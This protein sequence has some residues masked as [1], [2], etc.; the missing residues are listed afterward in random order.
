MRWTDFVRSVFPRPNGRDSMTRARW[1]DVTRPLSAD[2]P[3]Y[4]G[5][6]KVALETVRDPSGIAV[7]RIALHTHAGT[8]MDLPPHVDPNA[9]RPSDLWILNRMLGPCRLVRLRRRTDE[10]IGLD[11]LRAKLP[12]G[13]LVRLLLRTDPSA[14][15]WRGLSPE[16]ARH[17][18]PRLRVFGTDAMSVDPP[19]D[20]LEAHRILLGRGVIILEGLD[21][22]GASADAYDLLALPL[23]TPAVDGAPVRAVLRRRGEPRS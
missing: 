2:L 20:R 3:V 15:S 10:P 5:D 18:A 6:P 19:G 23:K 16:A 21:L 17:L 1:I 13:R 12:K 7:T 9:P 4:P 8:H 14:K 22:T 11:E